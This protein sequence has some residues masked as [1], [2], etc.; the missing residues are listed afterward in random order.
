MLSN[1]LTKS[2]DEDQ[3]VELAA[4]S[5]LYYGQK[6]I[7]QTGSLTGRIFILTIIKS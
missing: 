7:I 5:V 2:V 3:I 4:E 6:H 1:D